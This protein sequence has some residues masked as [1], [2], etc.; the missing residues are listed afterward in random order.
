MSRQNRNRRRVLSRDE[1]VMWSA[2]T[3]AIVPLRDVAAVELAGGEFDEPPALAAPISPSPKAARPTPAAVAAPPLA[4]LDRR[5]K[6]RVASGR[7][8][9]DARFDL[10]GLT[11]SEAHAALLGFLRQAVARE[12]RLV[13][14]ITGKSGVLRQQ[15]PHWLATPE[16][17]AL[18]I[19]YES[20]H[21][22][23]GGDGALYIR[24]R[25]QR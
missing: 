12:A 7:E 3:K 21:A 5:M 13:L 9:I 10:H 1:R 23:H 24:L 4:P 2:F 20:A 6:K 19:G 16:L 15:T 18:T 25:R 8:Q 11:Q 17:R 14:V 22:R